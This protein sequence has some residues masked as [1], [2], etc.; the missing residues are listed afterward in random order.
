MICDMAADGPGGAIRLEEA[1]K[2]AMLYF[3]TLNPN[4]MLLSPGAY[5]I[6]S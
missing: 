6:D 5:F 3:T 4:P 2:G 1:E